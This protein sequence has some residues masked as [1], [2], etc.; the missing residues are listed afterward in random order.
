MIERRLALRNRIIGVLLRHARRRNGRTKAECADA[1]GVSVNTFNAYEEG[2]ASVSLPELEVLG[3]LLDTPVTDL[4]EHD[5]E[6]TAEDSG[7]D[8]QAILA[9]R[10]RIIGA[11]L[12]QARSKADVTR[13]DL[14]ELLDHPPSRIADYEHGKQSVPVSELEL[15]ARHLDRP[16]DYFHNGREGAVGKWHRQRETDRRFH[17]LPRDMQE[18]VTKPI[19]VK[20]LELAMKLSEMP[21]SKLRSI[22]E[23]L[24]EITY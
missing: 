10:H 21:A 14:A 17:E 8:F 5:P 1:V 19:N 13:E 2:R 16:L 7:P 3:Y 12:R 15:L 22:A 18:F 24:L 11:L 23:G 4:T 6:L 9:L 20:Y